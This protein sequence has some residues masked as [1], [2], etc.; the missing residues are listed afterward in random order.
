MRWSQRKPSLQSSGRNERFQSS[1]RNLVV[2]VRSPKGAQAYVIG[3]D[4]EWHW[5][6]GKCGLPCSLQFVMIL[7]VLAF[8]FCPPPFCQVDRLVYVSRR[9]VHRVP[10]ESTRTQRR[11]AVLMRSVASIEC[12]KLVTQ[13]ASLCCGLG[14]RCAQQQSPRQVQPSNR[15]KM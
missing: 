13:I 2:R 15:G 12:S 10:L 9:H 6:D 8:K 3:S 14:H 4:A 5:R 7:A 1:K 11:L